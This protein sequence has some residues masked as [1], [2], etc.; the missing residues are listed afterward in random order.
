MA[1][2]LYFVVLFHNIISNM[3]LVV[4]VHEWSQ[5]PWQVFSCKLTSF[6]SSLLHDYP[7]TLIWSFETLLN[8]NIKQN[9]YLPFEPLTWLH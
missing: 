9:S 3:V 4:Q 6:W 2:S 8:K 1:I 7:I 5:Y